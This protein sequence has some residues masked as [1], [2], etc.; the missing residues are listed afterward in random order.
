MTLPGPVL[1]E[2]GGPAEKD[3]ST[4]HEPL[5]DCLCT[6]QKKFRIELLKHSSGLE[7]SGNSDSV[8]PGAR[9]EILHFSG[10]REVS[11]SLQPLLE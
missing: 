11:A 7:S 10:H 8:G 3:P 2:P 1:S 9:S 5:I 4:G 6:W